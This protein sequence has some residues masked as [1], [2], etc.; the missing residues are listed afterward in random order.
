LFDFLSDALFKINLPRTRVVGYST[1]RT[2]GKSAIICNHATSSTNTFEMD[3][4]DYM[5]RF[6]Y[7]VGCMNFL[8]RQDSVTWKYTDIGRI[9]GSR[10]VRKRKIRIRLIHGKCTVTYNDYAKVCVTQDPH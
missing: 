9:L 10:K 6:T 8:Y 1:T 2:T 5:L 4:I 7:S 3:K